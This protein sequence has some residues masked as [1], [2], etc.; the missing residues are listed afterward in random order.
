M[1]D[2]AAIR[3]RYLRDDLPIRLGGIAANLSRVKSFAAHDA[4]QAA[5]ASLLQESKFFIEW[6]AAEADAHTAAR[7]VELQ[8]QLARW[9]RN[10]D[11]IWQ[12][13][14]LRQQVATASGQWSQQI[15]ELSGLVG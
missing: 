13:R 4:N 12:D 3:E 1:K 11:R 15:L 14:T 7:L 2:W 5:V 6:A 8:V 9:Q 10:W